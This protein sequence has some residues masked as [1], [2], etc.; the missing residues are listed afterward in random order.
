[1]YKLYGPV[2]TRT[3]RVVWMLEEMGEPYELDP[4]APRSPEILA[5]NPSGKVPV[6]VDENRAIN[7]SSAIMTYL[8]DKHGV[9]TYPAGT[10]ERAEQDALFHTILD[11]IDA[12]LWVATR[13]KFILPED[14]RVPAIRDSITWEFDHNFQRLEKRFKGPF[15]MGDKMTIADILLIHCM[16]WAKNAGFPLNSEV[17]SA[18]GKEMRQR[19]AYLKMAEMAATA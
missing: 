5:L 18:Y 19:P 1:M 4:V 9:L 3:S 11:E 15:L 7:D 6:L 8:A 12:V 10:I 2:M 14:K 13:H 17:L 16:S